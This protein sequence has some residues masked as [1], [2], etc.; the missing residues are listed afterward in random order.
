MCP[1]PH[2]LPLPLTHTPH[3]HPRWARGLSACP[4]AA[5]PTPLQRTWT[6]PVAASDAPW[7]SAGALARLEMLSL[8]LCA[9]TS[10]HTN[11]PSCL[12]RRCALGPPG[13]ASTTPASAHIQAHQPPP[14]DT[15]RRC[16][17]GPPGNASSVWRITHFQAHQPSMYTATPARG[18]RCVG[19]PGCRALWGLSTHIQ[20]HQ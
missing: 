5:A 11:R 1:H 7:P 10:R 9:L 18:R 8:F 2:T 3:P 4:G 13:N 19:L 16:A 15:L 12:M 17:V 6:R 20:A 14:V